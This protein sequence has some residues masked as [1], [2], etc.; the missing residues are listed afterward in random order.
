MKKTLCVF[1]LLAAMANS[2]HAEYYVVYTGVGSCINYIYCSKPH[3]KKASH[4]YHRCGKR[5]SDACSERNYHVFYGR[6]EVCPQDMNKDY[7]DYS[8]NMD[9]NTADNDIE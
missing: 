2:V 5:V 3:R 9:M 1:V 8:P 6:P 4:H 7:I